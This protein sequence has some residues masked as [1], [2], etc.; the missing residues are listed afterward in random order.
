M[1]LCKLIK[2]VTTKIPGLKY[3][4]SFENSNWNKADCLPEYNYY[5]EIMDLHDYTMYHGHPWTN[6][7]NQ[8]LT[9]LCDYLITKFGDINIMEI[10]VARDNPSSSTVLTNKATKYFGIDLRDTSFIANNTNIFTLQASSFEQEKI[11]NFINH[12]PIHLLFIDGDHSIDTCLNDW[13]YQDL[14]VK[15]GVIALHDTNHHPGPHTLFEAVNEWDYIKSRYCLHDYGIGV[16]E[17]IN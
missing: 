12:T 1:G 14:V 16:I 3:Q 11:R 7:N 10:G 17:K 9:S 8:I 5:T 15:G 6:A 2:K 13:L 4:P